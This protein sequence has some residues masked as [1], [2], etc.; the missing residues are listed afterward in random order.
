MAVTGIVSPGKQVTNSAAKVGD[1]LLLTK[2]LGIGIITTGMKAGLVSAPTA[3]RI[4]AVMSTLNR[5]SCELMLQVGVN[6]CTDVTGFGFLGHLHEMTAA[7]GVGAKV[8]LSQVPVLEEAWDLVKEGIVP[9]GTHKN[10]RFL[11][12]LVLWDQAISGDSKLILCDAQTSGGLLISVPNGGGEDLLAALRESGV[13]AERV[14]ELTEDKEGKIQ[15]V[16]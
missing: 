4:I 14:G 16:P 15:V 8:S 1:E 13:M 12:E 2:P 6:A 5:K 7:S 3:E 10:L 9:G 11:E